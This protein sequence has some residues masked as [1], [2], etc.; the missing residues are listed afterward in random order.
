LLPL[1]P[2]AAAHQQRRI[3]EAVFVFPDRLSQAAETLAE[4][5]PELR[6]ELSR[7]LNWGY[8]RIPTI[9]LADQRDQFEK[10]AGTTLFSAFAVAD[11]D[12]IVLDHSRMSDAAALHA[13]LKHELCH[14]MLGRHIGRG[15]LPRWL[16]E[17]VAQWSSDG[18]SELLVRQDTIS[19]PAALSAG[20]LFDLSA[21]A[22]RFPGSRQ[23]LALAYSQSRSVVDFLVREYGREGLL[24]LLNGLK[25]GMALDAAARSA[26]GRSMAQ[27]EADWRDSLGR[28]P[29]WL[30]FLARHLY[31][32]LFVA[33]ALSTIYG[34]IR[35][36]LRQKRYAEALDD[37]DDGA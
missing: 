17:G 5:Y 21:L 18:L 35:L 14:L 33:A 16:N 7:S 4:V 19:L 34:F 15:R 26:L 23:G 30:L 3:G 11:R 12:L 36:R 13:T 24:A 2:S 25:A 27:V 22:D 32:L 31:E 20:R 10:W 8:D 6:K 29:A 9:V 37:E 28:D 1:F